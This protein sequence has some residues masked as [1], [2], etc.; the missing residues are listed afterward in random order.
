MGGP[1][2]KGCR[3]PL[4]GQAQGHDHVEEGNAGALEDRGGVAF[5][6]LEG[7]LVGVQVA[8]AVHDEGGVVGRGDG[9]PGVLDGEDVGGLAGPDAAGA[10]REGAL[11][12]GEAHGVSSFV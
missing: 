7:D 8:Q 10:Q 1:C 5:G 6:E 2:R 12:E 11:G 9:A 4:G 3:K